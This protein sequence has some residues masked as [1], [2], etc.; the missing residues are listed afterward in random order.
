M[1]NK[2]LTP[3]K[4]ELRRLKCNSKTRWTC[5]PAYQLKIKAEG[6][7]GP[8]RIDLRRSRAEISY[9]SAWPVVCQCE[10]GLALLFCGNLSMG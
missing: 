6:R 10:N 5:D 2:K 3:C 7:Q 8:I 9:A 4:P 1:R